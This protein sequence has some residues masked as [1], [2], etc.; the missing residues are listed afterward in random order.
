MHSTKIETELLGKPFILESGMLANLADGAVTVRW[1]DNLLLATAVMSRTTKPDIDF[2]PLTVEYQERFYATG[3]IPG[4]R[5]MKREGRPSDNAVLN[6]R[7]TD[8]PLRPLFPSG[9]INEVQIIVT[10]LS[11]DA[12]TDLGALSIIAASAAILKAGIPFEAPV[13]A[14]R[15]GMINGELMLNPTNEQEK[16]GQLDL[17]VAG[18]SDAILMVE[19]GASVVSEETLIKGMEMAHEFI[20]QVCALQK[21]FIAKF[22]IK[23]LIPSFNLPDESVIQ[24]IHDFMQTEDLGK[25]LYV[26]TKR[27]LNEAQAAIDEKVKTH[28]ASKI[29][30]ENE[31]HWTMTMVNAALFKVQKKYVRK[32]ILEKEERLDGRKLNEIRPISCMVGVLPRPHGSAIFKRGDTQ[33][34]SVVTLGAPGDAQTVDEM[35]SAEYER[36]YMH[37]YNMP[38]YSTGEAKPLRGTGRREIGHGYLAERAILAVLPDEKDFPYT[39]RVVSEVV[40]SNGS[41]SMASTCGSTLSLMDAGVPLKSP[42]S[43]IAM[44]MVSDDETGKYKILSDIQGMEDFTGDMDFKVAGT[45]DG[46]TALQMDIKVKGLTMN[47]M[48]EALMQ[49]HEGRMFILDEMLKALPTPRSSLSPYAPKI[50]TMQINPDQIRDVIGTGG[51][52]INEIIKETGVKIDIEDDG[53][54]SI[55]APD[56]ESGDKARKWIEGIVYIPKIGD[57][58]TGKVVRIAAFGVFVNINGGKD[59]LVHISNLFP[60]RVERIEGK[61]NI[62]DMMKVKVIGIDEQGKI[63]LSHKEF[64]TRA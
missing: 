20:K 5:F 40:A 59:G 11:V 33:A 53:F 25:T 37:H 6:S 36:R 16:T 58:L 64:E 1:G 46:V 30:D 60:Y 38:P 26:K 10:P 54:V 63:A 22:D 49:A 29:E 24:A 17:V 19:A 23:P 39:I 56:Q 31:P 44:G 3:K 32:N 34:L 55:T 27:E 7:L 45:K 8:R 28:F 13:A 21:E 12:Q 35:E 2:F 48:R 51:K 43:G 52:I 57:E 62:G 50:I 15:I 18:T 41:T 9:M 4:G 14:A 47:M 61:V 42:V